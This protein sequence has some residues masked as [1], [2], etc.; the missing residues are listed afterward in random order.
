M[1]KKFRLQSLTGA[2]V[3]AAAITV[4]GM[5]T[6]VPEFVSALNDY[7]KT[8]SQDSANIDIQYIK[9]DA[10]FYAEIVDQIR[11]MYPDFEFVAEQDGLTFSSEDITHNDQVKSLM[12]ELKVIEPGLYWSI[13][14]GCLG[15]ECPVKIRFKLFAQKLTVE[16]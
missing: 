12:T 16:S 2:S 15:R 1:F 14:N 3:L 10:K 11:P 5:A 4:A 9:K 7:N 6:S 13:E 8:S